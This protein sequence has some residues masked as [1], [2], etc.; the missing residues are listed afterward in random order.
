M[1]KSPQEILDNVDLFDPEQG[2]HLIDAL[3]IARDQCP[4][5]R[6][7]ADGGYYLLTRYDD[8]R[9]VCERPEDFSSARPAVNS[10]SMDNV[11]LVPL[12]ADPPLHRDFRKILN[13]FF[14]LS[15]VRRHEPA[16]RGIASQLLDRIV[17]KDHFEFVHD[18]AVPLTSGVLAHLFFTN[19]TQEF[20]R[21]AVATVEKL[22]VELS[23]EAFMELGMM[24]AEALARAEQAPPDEDDILSVISTATIDGGRPMTFEER[25]GI[26]AA[27][28]AGGLDTTRS[29]LAN[30]A[31]H[32][33]SRPDLEDRLRDPQWVR[34]DLDEF[35]RL[36]PT[37]SC[38][39][40]TVNH[41]TCVGDLQLKAGDRVVLS[42]LS[43]NRDDSRFR[44]PDELS[45]GQDRKASAAFGLGIHRCLGQ[46][47]AKLQIQVA[48][49][50]LLSRM[51]NL[52]VEPGADIPRAVGVSAG[53]PERLPLLFD[54]R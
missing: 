36:Q 51:T 11:R 41:D 24:G 43:A 45:F 12:D 2:E 47:L 3:K 6:T 34:N 22:A 26:V 9:D 17:E 8:V 33:A 18:Y 29:A 30:I 27:L 35:L 10:K 52:R 15:Y 28:L 49:D 23:A 5:L 13:K 38:S 53:A 19:E 20:M 32:L 25:L 1:A 31:Y 40:R 48:F 14:S 46:H 37:V 42:F 44:N 50:E 7:E 21:K 4:V 16:I 54:Q 39:A